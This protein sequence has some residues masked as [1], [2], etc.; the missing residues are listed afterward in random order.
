[1]S[2]P[3]ELLDQW[4]ECPECGSANIT[5][6]LQGEYCCRRCVFVFYKPRLVQIYDVPE[7]DDYEP[8]AMIKAVR[9]HPKG[10][11]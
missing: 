4:Y 7:I 9:Q 11:E 3:P 2:E 5:G 1:M 10:D 6:P 8:N